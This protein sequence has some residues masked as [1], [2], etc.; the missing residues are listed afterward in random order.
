MIIP[1]IF[2]NYFVKKWVIYYEVGKKNYI[3][4]R[5]VSHV[6]EVGDNFLRISVTIII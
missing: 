3:F 4:G 1:L 6:G 5:K 2:A